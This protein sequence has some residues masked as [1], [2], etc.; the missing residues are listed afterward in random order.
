M[1][2]KDYDEIEID[3]NE[4]L[5]IN[6]N[7]AVNEF[8]QLIED[9]NFSEEDLNN[10]K[11]DQADNDKYLSLDYDVLYGEDSNP[12]NVEEGEEKEELKHSYTDKTTVL[13]AYHNVLYRLKVGNKIVDT[14]CN[15]LNVGSN[16]NEL[17]L[18]TL[19]QFALMFGDNKSQT[20]EKTYELDTQ[21]KKNKLF[22]EETKT[23]LA[24]AKY[25]IVDTENKYKNGDPF[26]VMQKELVT[27]YLDKF[28]NIFGSIDA[29]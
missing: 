11:I 21:D 23:V 2:E 14:I 29:N 9:L 22:E 1:E 18:R 26:F 3:N 20:N 6:N 12:Y 16:T 24:F 17:D 4:E 13:K 7:I 25:P 27:P 19:A 10:I 15:K 28:N 8:D 5:N